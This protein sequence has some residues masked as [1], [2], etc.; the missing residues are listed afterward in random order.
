[1]SSKSELTTSTITPLPAKIK[2]VY[3]EYLKNWQ[4]KGEQMNIAVT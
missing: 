1:M 3:K 4:K 2:Y